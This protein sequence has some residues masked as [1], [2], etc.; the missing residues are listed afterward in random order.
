M[1]SETLDWLNRYVK[2]DPSVDT[3]PTFQW[4][5]QRGA[6]YSSDVMPTDP[7]FYGTPIND[8]GAGGFMPIVPIIGGSGPYGNPLALENSL[9]IPT[10]ASN[11][12]NVPLDLP[13]G[14]TQV[15]GAPVVT[16]HYSGLGTGR[17]V[18]GQI[19]DKNTGRVVGNVVTPIPVTLDGQVRDVTVNL[20]DIAYTAEPGDALL[21]QLV[22]SATPYQSFSSFGFINVSSVGV[23]L[24]T[25]GATV[26]PDNS[27]AAG[28]G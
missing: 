21:L 7:G 13:A 25:V 5:D 16:L 17:F 22:G 9:P 20:E 24:P 3:G 10:K 28:A 11:A 27:T 12:I 14:T 4:V 8:T 2:K 19:V 18:Y 1:T 15:V 6:F 26:A 23:S